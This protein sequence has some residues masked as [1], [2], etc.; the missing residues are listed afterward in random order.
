M[1]KKEYVI[2]VYFGAPGVGKTTIASLIARKDMKK[3]NKVWSNVPITGTYKLDTKNDIGNYDIYDGRIIIDE[4]G[5]EYNNR[6]Y[7]KFSQKEVKFFKYHRHNKLS[8][9]IFSQGYDDMDKKIRTLAQKYYV[10]KRS[11]IPYFIYTRRIAKKIDIDK[12][13]KQ[14]IDAYYFIPFGRRYYFAPLAWKLFNTY[15]RDKLPIKVWDKW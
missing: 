5:V 15:S 14:I 1:K 13:S 7:K 8:I 11:I 10:V 3:G 6:E 12:L 2:S 9:D 4:A